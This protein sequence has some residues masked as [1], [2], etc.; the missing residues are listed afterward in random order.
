M[1][2]RGTS[3]HRTRCSG[4]GRPTGMRTVPAYGGW[5]GSGFPSFQSASPFGCFRRLMNSSNPERA[6]A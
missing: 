4:H 3:L 5:S 1:T 6:W 2:L